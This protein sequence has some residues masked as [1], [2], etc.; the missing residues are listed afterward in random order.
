MP[1]RT[2]EAAFTPKPSSRKGVLL[3]GAVL[4]ASIF[5]IPSASAS[6]LENAA[7]HVKSVVS[8]V[9]GTPGPPPAVPSTPPSLPTPPPAPSAPQNT[10]SPTPPKPP[11]LPSP[12]K[13]PAEVP[14]APQ[15]P[16]GTAGVNATE[17]GSTTS[18]S[19]AAHGSAGS[20][21]SVDLPTVGTADGTGRPAAMAT[22][23]AAGGASRPAAS[24]GDGSGEV[25]GGPAPSGLEAGS[26][27]S[28][29]VAPLRHWIAYVWPAFPVGRVATLLASFLS[30][31][32]AAATSLLI[33]GVPQLLS[34]LGDS[35]PGYGPRNVAELSKHSEI[36]NPPA[37]DSPDLWIADGERVAPLIFIVLAAALMALLGFTLRRELRAMRRWHIP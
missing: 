21:A 11:K 15:N 33:S 20:G 22:N 25:P 17:A 23:P 37:A 16:R 2:R 24:T 4:I 26:V 28:A 12:P 30:G 13:P 31:D 10:P 29:R 7:D 6:P 5:A 3:V 27:G 18:G 1:T 34:D 8:Q 14:A 19:A 36:S 32:V 9:P 35:G